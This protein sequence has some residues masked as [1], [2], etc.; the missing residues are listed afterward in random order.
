M[1]EMP[2]TGAPNSI[3]CP[4]VGSVAG[5]CARSVVVREGTP[6]QLKYAVPLAASSYSSSSPAALPS[7]VETVPG[8]NRLFSP[9]SAVIFVI[10]LACD[11]APAM[12]FR[13]VSAAG[14][15]TQ[16]GQLPEFNSW[17]QVFA[18]VQ[19][20]KF[21][22]AVASVAKYCSPGVHVAGFAAVV[23]F[24]AG[25]VCAAPLKSCVP[26]VYVLD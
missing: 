4:A 18:A 3:T 1:V 24:N 15:V 13:L 26:V 11:P 21:C 19:K 16:F 25:S 14:A 6:S 22:P 9:V 2:P 23:P 8:T 20:N 10:L 5:T 17:V 12:M 7:P